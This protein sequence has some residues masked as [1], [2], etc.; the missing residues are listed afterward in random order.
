MIGVLF[1]LGAATSAP[2]AA[3]DWKL[4]ADGLGPARI[5]M[6]RSQVTKALKSKLE[7]EAFDNEGHCLELFPERED[8]EGT[9]FMFLD[10]KLSRISII[11]P[12]TVVTPRGIG[13]G[14]TADDIRKAYGAGL[15][16]S[17]HHYSGAPAEYLDYWLKGKRRGV[18]FETNTERKVVVFHAGDDSIGL[19]EGCA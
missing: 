5:G 4:T 14:S 9:Y 1:F 15:E 2:T 7:G 17:E 19:V 6:T 13:V 3:P 16:I 10:G 12:S 18:R 11:E 8:L